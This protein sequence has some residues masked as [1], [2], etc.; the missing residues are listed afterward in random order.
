[1]TVSEDLTT[2]ARARAD[3]ERAVERNDE[4]VAAGVNRP[5][6]QGAILVLRRRWEAAEAGE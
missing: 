1:M 6:G 3:Y 4:A 5:F 2:A